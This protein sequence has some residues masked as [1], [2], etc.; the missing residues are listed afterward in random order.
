MIFICTD[1]YIRKP[2]G[3]GIRLVSQARPFPHSAD[4]FQYE[5]DRRC[6][7]RVWLARL[8]LDQGTR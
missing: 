8:A 5:S 6:A 3:A 7:E 1:G 2:F 4:R